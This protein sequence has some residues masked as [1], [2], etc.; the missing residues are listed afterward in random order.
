MYSNIT[1]LINIVNQ[2]NKP[3]PQ[4]KTIHQLFEEQV[5]K[6]PDNIA[7][8]F[9]DKQLTYKELNQRSNQ[10]SRYIKD[11]Y[12]SITNQE[13]QPDSL[14]ALYLDR[15]LEM[16]ISILAV[17]KAGAAYVPISPDFPSDRT[18]YILEDTNST[19]LLSQTHL[20]D[21]LSDIAQ[22]IEIIATDLQEFQNYDKDNLNTNVQ[23]NNLAYVIYTSGTTGKP[24]GVALGHQGIINR[25]VWMQ[26]IYQLTD[27]DRILQKTPYNFDVSVWELL[28][29]N[30][31]GAAIVIA[32]PDGH[33]N[34]DY[35][36][37]LINKEK[38]TV[39]HFVP[40]MLDVFLNYLSTQ[41][42]LHSNLKIV[43][44]SGEALKNKTCD[45]FYKLNPDIALY[46]LYGPTE[47]SIDVSYSLCELGKKVTIGKPISNTQLYI[48]DNN[49]LPSPIGVPGELYIG[50]IGLA[51]GYLNLPELTKE[52]F[53][54]NPFATLDDIAKGYTRLYK[55][56]DICKWLA[57]GEIEYIGRN[58]FQVKLR[59]FRIELG[60]IENV[61][62]AIDNIKQSCVLVNNETLVAYYV[63]NTEI[64]ETAI[65]D[66]LAEKLPEYMIPSFYMRLESFPLTI[67]GKLDRR[68]LPKI[69][70]PNHKYVEP[71]ND[72]QKQLCRIWQDLLKLGKVG[73][74]DNFFNIG[75]NSILAITSTMRINQIT[76]KNYKVID[77]FENPTIEK[78]SN[79]DIKLNKDQDDKLDLS[80]KGLHHFEKVIFNHQL[81][82]GNNLIYN[83]SF[84][85]E[86]KQHINLDKFK[87]AAQYL[88]DKY[89]LLHSNYT[90]SNDG[91]LM[92][93]INYDSKYICAHK[94]VKVN[95]KLNESLNE[96]DR[97]SFD[98]STD[99]LIRFYLIDV[100]DSNK[101][102]IFISCHHLILDAT[103]LINIILPDLYNFLFKDKKNN[104]KANIYDFSKASYYI[105]KQYKNNFEHKLSFWK[106][107]LE[108]LHPLD[109]PINSQES[110]DK[111]QQ[112]SCKFNKEIRDKLLT[113][114]KKL[115]SSEFSILYTLFTLLLYKVSNQN[116]F[117]IITNVDERLYTPQYRDII[118]C[119]INNVF[120]TTNFD[121]N[122][123]LASFITQSKEEIISNIN[124]AIAYE[125]LLDNLD[126]E[127]IRLLSDI[128][129]N[130]ETEETHNL[131]Y[132]QT[133]IYSHSGYVKHGL[134][135]EIDL[136]ND[137]ILCR[138][139]FN[140][141]YDRDFIDTLIS[142]YKTLLTQLDILLNK[143]ISEISIIDDSQY[144]QILGNS[145]GGYREYPQTTIYQ[146]FEEQVAKTPDN[147]ALV[148]EDKQLTYKELNQKSNQL[149]RYITAKYKSITN[150]E[151]QPDTLI[152]LYLDRSLEMIISILA[153]LK[154]GAAY[155]PISPDFPSDRT[156]YIL[157]DTNA[158]I[159]LSQS[160]LIGKLN[161]IAQ[162]IEIIATDSQQFQNY[163]K[164]NLN[165]N[166]QPNNLAYV[167]YTSGTTG[168]PKGVM[169]EHY[170]FVSFIK[171]FSEKIK[172][173]NGLNLLSLTNIVFDIFGLEYALPLLNG[174]KLILSSAD[175]I[176]DE[177]IVQSNIIQQTP[178]VISNLCQIHKGKFHDKTLLYGGEKA[179]NNEVKV[180]LEEFKYVYNVYGPAETTIWSSIKEVDSSTK[181]SVIGTPLFNEKLYVLDNNLF[182]SPI[183][184]PGELYIGG[185]GLARGY[186]NLPQLTKE[187]FINNPFATQDDIAKGYTRLYKTG[188]ICKWL[189]N[190]EIE[191]IGRN[192]F[193][194]KLRGFRI[195]LGEIENVISAIDNIK[196]SC[197]LVKDEVLVA[198]YVANTEI[199][200]IAIKN[201]LAE[202][203]PEY[204]IPSFYM[205]LESFPLTINGKL[206]RRALPNFD[207]S[208]IKQQYLAPT[209]EL[210]QQMCQIWQEVLKI[211]KVGITDNFFDIGGN[212]ILS[213]QA[214]YKMSQIFNTEISIADIFRYKTIA[215]ILEHVTDEFQL[216]SYFNQKEDNKEDLLFI[217]PAFAGC[218]VYH[219]LIEKLSPY[220]NC[221][222]VENYNLYAKNKISSLSCLAKL[223]LERLDLNDK[224][225]QIILL[226]WSLGGLIAFEMAYWLERNGF[227][228]IQLILLD[229]HIPKGKIEK[230][231]AHFNP[232]KG[233][234]NVEDY[235]YELTN[236]LDKNYAQRV[237]DSKDIDIVLGKTKPTGKLNNTEI[238]LFKA[239]NQPGYFI[240]DNNLNFY[241]NN[242]NIL[243]FKVDHLSLISNIIENWPK[244]NYSF[245]SK[246]F[247]LLEMQQD[248]LIFGIFKF[249]KL[250]SFNKKI[251]STF[252]AT[253]SIVGLWLTDIFDFAIIG[254]LI[255]I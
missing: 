55:T 148:F 43:F 127:H 91:E 208:N 202:K 26:S 185:A 141:K 109:L 61:I 158:T 176:T 186:L 113:V 174:Y 115:N 191:Y 74:T 3:F 51:R 182:P 114:S 165:T 196:Q 188:D 241:A 206:D 85:I 189:A 155:V 143:K 21:K 135:F 181:S 160:H 101:Q 147:I 46:N 203:L 229:P 67:N 236:R 97:I 162:D 245:I 251:T 253:I 105:D 68:A 239:T 71:S 166:V 31:Y 153:V 9:E 175:K 156:K 218:E 66:H 95:S 192:D 54:D 168:K 42:S 244:Y 89:M 211:N 178:K 193:Q 1:D 201:H 92:R 36:Y 86:Y 87:L 28:W 242:F 172:T 128:Q 254:E 18:K 108:C 207:I 81:S 44:C 154:S 131:P 32:K 126:R 80:Y 222:G 170:S 118:G 49:L 29:A 124:N 195:E 122:N 233:G 184:V 149:A 35:L 70:Q 72:F 75:G 237:L 33:K 40:S 63:A 132:N 84:V 17:I 140:D 22:D 221:I 164:D 137:E 121:D 234:R 246:R 37:Q 215:N 58:D 249:K 133:Q 65:K 199:D 103:S 5:A 163:A 252:I 69:Q 24:K 11:E 136:K 119:L 83:E 210:Q 232:D 138:V 4:N 34:C 45:N 20:I 56:G 93:T 173:N 23:P 104:T 227:N 161:E 30:W 99:K 102:Y 7:L 194:V 205:R 62:S 220:Y 59:G 169:I 14:I 94:V 73:I 96:I 100:L 116:N 78:L 177:Q 134:Y 157:E 60:E 150:Q 13:L 111:G 125:S 159:L 255:L 77:L 106:N 123:N 248:K 76:N 146:L 216:I 25:I 197:V 52:R 19:I 235:I 226:G 41:E 15:S 144:Q 171:L 217:H 238:T 209:T 2:T 152:A 230:H 112:I 90:Y 79:L 179:A 213:I 145:N 50:G 142:G 228:N 223:Y 16:V 38:I 8:V 88:L 12:K 110:F 167:I 240:K 250:L 200:E 57:N 180:F 214:A 247:D 212:S 190:G 139:E 224:N 10:L 151:L 187:R 27:K 219:A 48:L 183:G 129:F 130:L 47:A 225:K 243:Y 98:L 231:H 117:A 120:F 6:T 204:M 64:D 53:I 198:Y 39:A 82:S 107:K